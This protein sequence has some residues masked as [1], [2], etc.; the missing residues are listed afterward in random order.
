MLYRLVTALLTGLADLYAAPAMAYLLEVKDRQLA[1]TA[2]DWQVLDSR[3]SHALELAP[4]NPDYWSTLGYLQQIGSRQAQDTPH[5]FQKEQLQIQAY[6]SYAQAA[7]LRPTWPYDWG[8]M[9]LEQY[10]QANF[11]SDSYHRALVNAAR[12]GPWKDDVQLLVGELSLD[13]WDDL[14]M[15]ARLTLLET[16]DRGLL[17]QPEEMVAIIQAHPAWA[18]VCAL[19]QDGSA[20]VP[21]LPNL[22]AECRRR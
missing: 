17:R 4:D 16:I 6:Q 18:A 10:R 13:T 15:A 9:A 3:L 14:N 11:S 19:G 8:D 20:A 21:T 22:V 7:A 2:E 5:P 12:Y 1:L